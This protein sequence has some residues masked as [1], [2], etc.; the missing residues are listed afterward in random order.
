MAQTQFVM[1]QDTSAWR[2]QVWL[3]FAIAVL[4]C[5]AGIWQMP[6]E[7]LDR[8]FLAI[9]FFFCLSATFALQKTVR[10]NRDE[11][12]DTPAWVIQVWAAFVIA[13]MLTGWGM[14]R[15]SIPYWHKGYMIAAGFYLLSSTFTLAKTIRDNHEAD[16]S[17]HAEYAADASQNQPAR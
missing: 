1:R 9:G 12:V 15:L 13:I 17:T 3:S 2:M 8:A 14:W 7:S 4:L 5:G 11:K 6:S 16:V 10:D